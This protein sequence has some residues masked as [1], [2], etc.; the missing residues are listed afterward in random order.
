MRT[1]MQI[2]KQALRENN[3]DYIRENDECHFRIHC[4]CG[5]VGQ[6]QAEI[7]D[8]EEDRWYTQC[9]KCGDM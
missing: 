1:D 5:Y 4:P 8:P 3:P 6:P 2:R 9:P 7:Y